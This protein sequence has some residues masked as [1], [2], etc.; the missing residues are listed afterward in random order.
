MNAVRVG[1]VHT[2]FAGLTLVTLLTLCGS[3]TVGK[4]GPRVSTQK[5]QIITNGVGMR[6]VR[7]PAGKFKMGSP[8]NERDREI[9]FGVLYMGNVGSE[10]QH[11]VEITKAFFLG[12][13]AVTQGEFE[14]VMGYNP[15]GFSAD[16]KGEPGATY[17]DD[18]K[19]GGGADRVKGLDTSRFPVENVCWEEADRFCRKLSQLKKE[20]AAGR[21]YRLPTEAEWEYAC[22]GGGASTKPFNIDSKPTDRLSSKDANFAGDL[23]YGAAEKEPSLGRTCAVGSYKP[24]SFGLYDMHGNVRQWCADW[25]DEDYYAKSPRKDPKG[26]K[27]GKVR[28][29]RGGSW[30][31]PGYRCRA[32]FRGLGGEPDARIYWVGFR[33][34]FDPGKQAP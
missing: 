11:E 31:S 9:D 20:K 4:E 3:G 12:V 16:A 2:S 26:P 27:G 28:V 14:K 1:R 21:V 5:Q 10:Q 15:S 32:A 24:N 25:Y 23:P 6:L 34:A 18:W 30:E 19:P 29:I 7:I 17:D 22:R 8:K 33:I 13:F